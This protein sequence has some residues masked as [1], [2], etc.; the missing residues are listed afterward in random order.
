MTHMAEH[1]PTVSVL[2]NSVSLSLFCLFCPYMP[3]STARSDPGPW[4]TIK[5]ASYSPPRPAP[6][7]HPELAVA[8]VLEV[9]CPCV[10]G[11]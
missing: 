3:P 6:N 5:Y 7:H 10:P 11:Q 1:V 9:L 2:L 4:S 8:S